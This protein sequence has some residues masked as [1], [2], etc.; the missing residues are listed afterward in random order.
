[1]NV[2]KTIRPRRS[3]IFCPGIRPD[4]FEKALSAGSDMVCVELEDGIAPKDKKTA[5]ERSLPLFKNSKVEE[6]EKILRIN[7]IR[8]SFGIDDIQAILKMSNPP[9]AIMLPKVKSPDEVLIV[10]SLLKESNHKTKLHI[11][12]ETNQALESAVEIANCCSRVDALFFGLIDM[13]AELRCP[14]SWESLLYARSRVVHAA[15]SAGID[16]IDGPHLDLDDIE[17]MRKEAELAFELGFSGKG[18]IHPKQIP[19]LNKIFTPSEEKIKR[20]KKIISLFENADT[21]LV[22]YEG[23]LIEKPVIREM[24]R[25]IS[26]DSK[27]SGNKNAN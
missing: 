11:I 16:V 17:G 14:V 18:A 24:R 12:I 10:D 1:M 13:A 19:I 20:A 6:V 2:R 23:K 3:F 26:I 21:G 7:S 4:L 27:I 22:M 25:V 9:D 8:E 5:R 15:A